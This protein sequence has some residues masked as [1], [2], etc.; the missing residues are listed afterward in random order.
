MVQFSQKIAVSVA[1]ILLMFQNLWGGLV[2]LRNV[3]VPLC[4]FLI[5]HIESHML[6]R[7]NAAKREGEKERPPDL[8]IT[9]FKQDKKKA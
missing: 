7:T 9:A 2:L 8:P 1:K 4:L 6:G 5:T 3:Q